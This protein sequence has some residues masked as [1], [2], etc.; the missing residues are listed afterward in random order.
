MAFHNQNFDDSEG[1]QARTFL[2]HCLSLSTESNSLSNFAL[3][4]SIKN[5]Q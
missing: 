1:G 5:R 3:A 4:T 2:K